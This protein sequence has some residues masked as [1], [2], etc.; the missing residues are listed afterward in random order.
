MERFNGSE[1]GTAEIYMIQGSEPISHLASTA[2]VGQ[3]GVMDNEGTQEYIVDQGLYYPGSTNYYG[4]YCT[5]FESTGE[6]DNNT[7][8]QYAGSQTENLPYV[9]YTPSYGYAQSPYN[10]YNPYI[11]GAVIGVDGSFAGMQQYYPTPTYQHPVSSQPYYPLLAQP[12]TENVPSNAQESHLLNAGLS[13]AI[14]NTG[15]GLKIN[16]QAASG[17]I[18]KS[19]PKPPVADVDKNSN[20]SHSSGKKSDTSKLNAVN[21]K[22]NTSTTSLGVS[23]AASSQAT[24]GRN[25]SGTVQGVDQSTFGQVPSLR[26]P[27]NLPMP[28]TP[29]SSEYGSNARGWPPMVDKLRPRLHYGGVPNNGNPDFLAEQNRG[30]R[31]NRSRGQ[32]TPSSADVCTTNSGSPKANEKILIHPEDYNKEDFQVSY[33]DGKFFVIKS[34]SEDDVH[35]SIKYNVWSSTPN[36]NKR[37]HSAYGDAQRIAAA[38]SGGCPVFLFFS[39][40]ASGQFCGVAEMI[41]PVDFNKDMNFW[42]QDKWSGSFPVKWHIIK[43]VP[44]TNFRHIILENNENKPVTNSRD[45]QEIKSRPGMEMLSIFKKY[46]LK[47]SILDDFMYYEERQ[48]VMQDEKATLHGKSSFYIPAVV[49]LKKSDQPP[50]SETNKSNANES[51]ND[52]VVE[53]VNTKDNVVQEGNT[54]D[55][56]VEAIGALTL[57]SKPAE[58]KMTEPNDVI[59]VG[60]MP[61]KVNGL[62]EASSGILTVGSI[63]IV[64]KGLAV[65]KTS[66]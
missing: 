15:S 32:W 35:K 17:G 28:L 30:P 4:Y 29:T 27:V 11:P 46:T 16:S 42:Q 20:Q 43:D 23:R 49:L 6:W 22:T 50:S 18:V 33:P 19:P 51:T 26:S 7:S 14:G 10:P 64:P 12:L 45:T 56:V 1:Y 52:N 53:E 5:G 60:S 63:P 47:T 39:V 59:T 44:N 9:Y 65:D 58:A 66:T 41:G 37:L 2:S 25:A 62:S 55:N 40:N 38:K 54:K 61:V 31:T 34:Y 36:G 21:S 24:Q 13:N 57:E 48:K 3:F 8:L